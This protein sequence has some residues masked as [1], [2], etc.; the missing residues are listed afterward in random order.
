[1]CGIAGFLT[2]DL[3]NSQ[4]TEVIVKMLSKLS[5]RG[6]DDEGHW[7]DENSSIVLGH[8]R[9]SILDLSS[10]GHQ[11]MV[12]KSG[13]YVIAFNGEIYNYKHIKKQL[14]QHEPDI[15]WEG[16]SDTEILLHAIQVFGLDAALNKTSGMFAIALWDRT[17]SRF[18]LARDRVGE[19]PLYYSLKNSLLLFASDLAALTQYPGYK[20]IIDQN[21]LAL[22]MKY[23][24]VPAP[25][26]IFCDTWKVRSGNLIE[27]SFRKGKIE[28]LCERAYWSLSNQIENGGK[29]DLSE[30][31]YINQ[32]EE[33]IK[34]SVAQCMVADVPV[35]AFLSGGIDSSLVVA[36]MQQ[37][38][39]SQV[40][41]YTIGFSDIKYNEAICAK[42]IAEHLGTLHTEYYISTKE[43][44]E[45]IPQLPQIYSEPFSD[46]SQI[47]TYL[48]SKLAR[49]EVAVSLSG[50][51]G[52]ELFGGYSR[53]LS[54][55][56]F[57]QYIR[58]LPYSIRKLIAKSLRLVG[59][60]RRVLK[61]SNMLE[62]KS[63][64]EIYDILLTHWGLDSGIIKGLDLTSARFGQRYPEAPSNINETELLM[65]LDTLGY[66][67]DDI[68]TKVDRAAMAISLETRIPLLDHRVVEYAWKLPMAMK[69]RNG[70]GKWILRQI[71]KKFVPEHMFE[72]PKMG[73]SIPLNTWLTTS[74]RDWAESL[75][76]SDRIN[77]E[78]NFDAILINDMWEQHLSGRVDRSG[79]LWDVL[80]FQSW[81]EKLDSM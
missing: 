63:V 28:K 65:Y 71:L 44:L 55:I 60:G 11:P 16:T 59:R 67:Q 38:S 80:M 36:L 43:A 46:S 72:R 14:D 41:T 25:N 69:I 66:M 6:P 62:V 10:R 8:R 21:S 18:F 40:N 53:Y 4:K 20:K 50:D 58:Y 77:C 33:K 42:R 2:N 81:Y 79:L 54:S 39:M 3:D 5:H 37:Q 24:C 12:S 56:Q 32:L 49:Q 30:A 70:N 23:N 26:A 57:R 17:E 31:E 61:L 15:Q 48:V 74:L 13:R 35:G 9:L 68:L 76:N 34:N 78:N 51:G 29:L 75:L 47:P 22:Y 73:F 19:K 64:A 1:M 7:Q 45:V 52:D 27:F